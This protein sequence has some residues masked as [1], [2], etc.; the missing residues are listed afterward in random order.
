MVPRTRP[1]EVCRRMQS[2]MSNLRYVTNGRNRGTAVAM[3][4]GVEAAR[5]PRSLNLLEKTMRSLKAFDYPA[6]R[7]EV[8]VVGGSDQTDAVGS[9]LQRGCA[10]VRPGGAPLP[11]RCLRGDRT[12]TRE[13]P[14]TKVLH[15]TP[16]F[17]IRRPC[18]RRREAHFARSWIRGADGEAVAAVRLRRG[19]PNRRLTQINADQALALPI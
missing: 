18:R 13:K 17:L 16:L 4:R 3:S 15:L 8:P 5:G 12:P 9:A 1:S 6:D 14:Q 19:G 7:Y 10:R 2:S 11:P